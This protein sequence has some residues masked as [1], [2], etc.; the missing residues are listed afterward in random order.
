MFQAKAGMG[1]AMSVIITR[2]VISDTAASYD[3]FIEQGARKKVLDN[4]Q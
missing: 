3:T 4:G 1:N 2:V